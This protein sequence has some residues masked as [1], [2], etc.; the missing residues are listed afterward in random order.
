MR[1]LAF[2]DETKALLHYS[3]EKDLRY[4]KGQHPIWVLFN[5]L[6]QGFNAAI[7]HAQNN[8][9]AGLNNR[10]NTD[11]I[12]SFC[13]YSPWS[14]DIN[15]SSLIQAAFIKAR[16]VDPGATLILNGQLNEVMGW[17][18]ADYYYQFAS[19]LKS[20]GIPIDGVGFEMHNYI[21]PDSR[22]TFWILNPAPEFEYI[23]LSLDDYLEKVD[24][25]VKR[26]ASA[27]LKVA[28]TE[29]DCA[30]DLIDHT[31]NAP[32]DRTPAASRVEYDSRLQ[33]QAKYYAGLLKIA[34][35]ND[36]VILYRMW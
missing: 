13:C 33:W 22:M 8:Y 29:V 17:R 25:N 35:E 10:Q 27:G 14:A 18:V 7:P 19:D 36:N 1:D 32:L 6:V 5:E 3:I 15:D 31:T 23:Y 9:P 26:Y 24:L 21:T 28:F 2:P 16:E 30:I 4:T 34:M 12:A 11:P 20:Q